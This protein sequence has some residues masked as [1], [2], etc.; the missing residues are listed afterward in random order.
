MTDSI[1]V[2]LPD[3][4]WLA[5]DRPALDAALAAGAEMALQPMVAVYPAS[6]RLLTSAQLADQL[7][8]PATWLEEAARRSEVPCVRLGKYLRFD[9]DEVM[10][11]LNPRIVRARVVSKPMKVRKLA[12]DLGIGGEPKSTGASIK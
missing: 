2:P 5:L 4:R 6:P 12:A 7:N 9:I 3:G 11:S 10:S 8:V 1:V